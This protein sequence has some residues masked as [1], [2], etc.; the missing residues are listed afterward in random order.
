MTRSPMLRFSTSPTAFW[1]SSE[2]AACSFG[3]TA[4][5]DL[6]LDTGPDPRC[7]FCRC[8]LPSRSGARPGRDGRLR[9]RQNS[10]VL[11]VAAISSIAL[12]VA[13]LASLASSV[14]C[15]ETMRYYAPARTIWYSRAATYKPASQPWDAQSPAVR[16]C[17]KRSRGDIRVGGGSSNSWYVTRRSR[18]ECTLCWLVPTW[19]TV[20]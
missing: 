18:G 1:S 6:V 10:S 16:R 17:A 4:R 19:S 8:S 20:G 2:P 14:D 7:S 13:A 3:S 9:E 11:L 12:C 5:A 15:R